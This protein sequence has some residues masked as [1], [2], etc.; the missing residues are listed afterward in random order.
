MKK[1]S[2]IGLHHDGMIQTTLCRQYGQVSV[3]QGSQN[4]MRQEV[5]VPSIRIQ[6]KISVELHSGGSKDN[7]DWHSFGETSMGHT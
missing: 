6:I 5:S 7:V 4:P 1:N 2:R 3:G